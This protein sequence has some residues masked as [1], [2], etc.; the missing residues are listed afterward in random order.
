MT[1]GSYPID[2]IVKEARELKDSWY[3]ILGLIDSLANFSSA[4]DMGFIQVLKRSHSKSKSLEDKLNSLILV[5][6]KYSP[7]LKDEVD[8]KIKP[9]LSSIREL[10]EAF[11]DE[12]ANHKRY[13]EIQENISKIKKELEEIKKEHKE[14]EAKVG[15]ICG[16]F[17]N[18]KNEYKIALDRI[19]STLNS[20]LGELKKNFI[21]RVENIAEGCV[22]LKAGEEI[23]HNEL[24]S[25]IVKDTISIDALH[26]KEKN[27]RRKFFGLFRT[28]DIEPKEKLVVLKY[29][30]EEI[31]EKARIIKERHRAE[32]EEVRVAFADLDS[33]EK[34]CSD[35]DNR[36][37]E[38]E[39]Y[40]IELKEKL[41]NL[42]KELPDDY[43]DFNHIIEVKTNLSEIFSKGDNA[44]ME[45]IDFIENS[46]EDVVLETNPEKRRLRMKIKELEKKVEEYEKEISSLKEKLNRYEASKKEIEEELLS[47]KSELEK[48]KL[49]KDFLEKKQREIEEEYFEYKK[50]KERE[51]E[52]LKEEIKKLE[53]EKSDL[54]KERDFKTKRI[55]E[56]EEKIDEIKEKLKSN[57]E[58]LF[59]G[60]E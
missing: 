55:I 15:L 50:V 41:F 24:F 7:E 12:I 59:K 10:E 13:R 2:N 8:G 46:M 27:P 3:S 58:D 47:T 40:M 18:R 30:C 34:A 20:E 33:L 49:E 57:V 9:I 35:I 5:F 31:A 1:G 52:N 19:K 11:N 44:I 39:S 53:E 4:N 60:V 42:E 54:I 14:V 26:L 32:A 6:K 25:L 48:I 29:L 43:E 51:I 17:F 23:S 28:G 45:F 36:R 56:L 38:I 37:K 16:K 22:V 21:E